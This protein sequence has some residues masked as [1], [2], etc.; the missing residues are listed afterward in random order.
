MLTAVT[1]LIMTINN[2][3]HKGNSKKYCR[4]EVKQISNIQHQN[5][6]V[7]RLPFLKYVFNWHFY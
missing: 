5:I 1:V 7:S 3:A 4:A 2:Q 6:I